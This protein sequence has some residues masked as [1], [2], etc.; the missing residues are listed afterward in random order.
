MKDF[1][2]S[3]KFTAGIFFMLIT[4]MLEKEKQGKTN[5]LFY[6]NQFQLIF[7]EHIYFLT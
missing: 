5:K 3:V 7:T 1:Y 4:L 6:R 2:L